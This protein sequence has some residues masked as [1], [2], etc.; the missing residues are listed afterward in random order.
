MFTR[1]PTGRLFAAS[2]PRAQVEPLVAPELPDP[3]A[4]PACWA[5]LAAIAAAGHALTFDRPTPMS[6][7]SRRRCSTSP[8]RSNAPSR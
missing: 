1:T 4:H 3:A 2:I 8:A 5:E 6:R 7:P